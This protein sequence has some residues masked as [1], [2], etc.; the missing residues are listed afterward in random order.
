LSAGLGK[1]S[2]KKILV[3]DPRKK[4]VSCNSHSLMI[5]LHGGCGPQVGDILKMQGLTW[6]ICLVL[7][8]L[9]WECPHP[10]AIPIQH[11]TPSYLDNIL[12]LFE[13]AYFESFWSGKKLMHLSQRLGCEIA[14]R[15]TGQ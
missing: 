2:C 1:S 5:M 4:L 10:W 15:Q 13:C 12:N 9:F 8:P 3:M 14:N 6:C 7:G 11:K